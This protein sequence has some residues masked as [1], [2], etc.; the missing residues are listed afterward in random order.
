M[1]VNGMKI[2]TFHLSIS[3]WLDKLWFVAGKNL[4]SY[5]YDVDVVHLSVKVMIIFG[6]LH[7]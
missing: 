4:L 3:Y 6:V 7:V 1:K 2:R 5:V